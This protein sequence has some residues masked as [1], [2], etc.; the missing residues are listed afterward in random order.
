MLLRAL[1]KHKAAPFFPGAKDPWASNVQS[2]STVI[3]ITDEET[4]I[5]YPHAPQSLVLPGGTVPSSPPVPEIESKR[6][7]L[8]MSVRSL[9]VVDRALRYADNSNRAERAYPQAVVDAAVAASMENDAIFSENQLEF[10]EHFR[11]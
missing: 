3:G 4:G 6:R 2:M 7:T 8:A 11:K 5:W 1:P 10:S 9:E